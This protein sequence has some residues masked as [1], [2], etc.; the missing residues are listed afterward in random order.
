MDKPTYNEAVKEAIREGELLGAAFN[1]DVQKL[2]RLISTGLSI[3]TKD[4]VRAVW[5]VGASFR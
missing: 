4:D 5:L 2:R 3:E 1:G